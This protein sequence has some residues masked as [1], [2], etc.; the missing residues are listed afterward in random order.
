MVVNAAEVAVLVS[1]NAD[2]SSLMEPN[3]SA[4]QSALR[5]IIPSQCRVT[6]PKSR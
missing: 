2:E 1:I 6:G 4:R 3:G 5:G